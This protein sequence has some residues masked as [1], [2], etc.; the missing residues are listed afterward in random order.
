MTTETDPL[1]ELK[2][3]KAAHGAA[4]QDTT[5]PLAALLALKKQ[6]EEGT[7]GIGSKI[8]G[9]IAS[10]V[11]DIPGV[12]AAQAGVRAAVRTPLDLIKDP[13]QAYRNALSDI[14]EAEDAAPKMAT[15]PARMAG[16]VLA[17]MAIPGSPALAGARYGALH[18]LGSA[19]PDASLGERVDNAGIEMATGGGL[20]AVASGV[21]GLRALPKG[22]LKRI[23]GAAMPNNLR[24]AGRVIGEIRAATTPAAEVAKPIIPGDF[25]EPPAIPVKPAVATPVQQDLRPSIGLLEGSGFK[26]IAEAAKHQGS[27]GDV[28]RGLPDIAEDALVPETAPATE[29]GLSRVAQRG[30]TNRQLN[31]DAERFGLNTPRLP[32]AQGRP[33][34]FAVPGSPEDAAQADLLMRQLLQSIRT[35]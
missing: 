27:F 1:E 26:N 28:S 31:A 19:D 21:Q 16:G 33:V 4:P 24:R 3:L 17:A 32:E 20:G 34:D 15:V 18:A 29:G 5:D 30:R 23:A 7:P 35:P 11:R 6:D 9:T 2:K 10:T 12:E 8:L 13:G 14:H 22:S 25:L